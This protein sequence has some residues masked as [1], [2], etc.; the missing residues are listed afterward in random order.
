MATYSGGFI[1]VNQA[2]FLAEAARTESRV[3]LAP[4]NE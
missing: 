2:S 3:P 1:H 4:A